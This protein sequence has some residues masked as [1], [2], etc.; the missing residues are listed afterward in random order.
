MQKGNRPAEA[1]NRKSGRPFAGRHRRNFDCLFLPLSLAVIDTK[2]IKKVA[3]NAVNIL[4]NGLSDEHQI[5]QKVGMTDFTQTLTG[6]LVIAFAISSILYLLTLRKALARCADQSREAS[7][8]SVWLMLIPIFQLGYHF[9]LVRQVSKSLG[10]ELTRRGIAK[11]GVEPGKTLGLYTCILFVI[12]ACLEAFSSQL[13]KAGLTFVEI[14]AL[15]AA[16]V[17]WILYWVKVAKSSAMIRGTLPVSPGT[18]LRAA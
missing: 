5:K 18:S 8:N 14:A 15:V 16:W 4:Q 1:A 17:C 3:P 13:G 10:N 7:P 2:G 9:V 6:L 11:A 12:V